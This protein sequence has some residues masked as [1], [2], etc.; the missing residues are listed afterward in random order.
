[1]TSRRLRP[2]LA[3][4]LVSTFLIAAAFGQGSKI[5]SE[6]DPIE[7]ADR[8]RPDKRAEWMARGR[9]APAGKSS[10]ALRL[11]AHHQKM[12][13]RASR[14]A[15]AAKAG[16]TAPATPGWIGLGPAPL[17]SDRNFF[18]LVSGRATSVAIDKSDPTGNTVYV[19]GAYGG[20]WKS[21]NATASPASSVSW[22][23]V[24]DQEASLATGAV[25]VKPDGTVVLVG[26]GEPN[27]AIDSYYG[28]GILRS[29]DDGTTW[30]LIPSADSGAHSFAGLGVAKFAWSTASGQTSTVV[31]ALATTAKGFEE[32]NITANTNRG[33][34]RSTDAGLTWTFQALPD[35]GPI[36]ATDVV[37]DATAGK[38]VAAV[39]SHGLYTSTNGTNWT[40]SASQP[41]VLTSACSTHVNCPIYRGQLA[42][43]PG[44]DEVYFWFINID[45]NGNM[46]DEGIWR[47]INGG[48]WTQ[49]S[50]TGLTNCGEAD[51]CG[52]SQAFYNLEIAGVPDGTGITDLY[53]GAV[54]LFKCKLSNSQTTCSTVDAK[55]PN[56]WLNLTHVYGICSSK[57]SVHPDEHGL[58]FAVINGK[59]LI[60][61]ANDGGIY[62]AL[63]G[64]TG[65]NIGSCNTAGNNQ[66]D[67]LNAD[68]WL[69]DAVCF[70]FDSSERPGHD[71][72]RHA[73]QRFARQR[74][75]HVE[76][77]VDHSQRG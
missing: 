64:Y 44:R 59:A 37:Y 40:R 46:V 35:G 2:T 15:A 43:V 16:R 47:S 60:Y 45:G 25:S 12:A 29:T 57:A 52:V 34:Y 10:A 76:S 17:V 31:A 70:V 72:R 77:T 6:Y 18:G 54:N 69:D 42:V 14:Q 56:S 74:R 5:K 67:N 11:N 13:A 33:L 8:D 55:L 39:R 27:N 9:E 68:H 26:T 30:T 23:P 22:T 21:V 58:D 38:F 48:S 53:A 71:F 19:G 28:V 49:I 41:P 65:L 32:G 36:S 73:G 4:F 66:F 7:D 62:R 50:E 20:V 3:S 51:G 24:T 1:M 61:F 63:D 75:R